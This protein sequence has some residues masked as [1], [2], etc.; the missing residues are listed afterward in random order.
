[1]SRFVV[2]ASNPPLD[3]KEQEL[4][5]MRQE[6]QRKINRERRAVLRQKRLPKEKSG[7]SRPVHSYL[8]A[9]EVWP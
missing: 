9:W 5:K 6:E 1:M 3:K 8:G 2:L 7:R 4:L